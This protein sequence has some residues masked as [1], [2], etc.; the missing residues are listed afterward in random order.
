MHAYLSDFAVLAIVVLALL[1][2]AREGFTPLR[3]GRWLWIAMAA[4]LI[5]VVV[6]VGLG[7]V[8]SAAYPWRTH[9]V[10]AA[11]W[12]EYALLAPAVPLLVRRRSDLV[13]MLWSLALWSAAATCAGL[14]EFA[15]AHIFYF[16]RV[17]GRQGSFLSESD[18]AALSGAVLLVGLIAL[19]V[20]RAELGR[21]LGA[22]ATA[23]G[24][25][26]VALAGAVASVFG[27]ATGGA[28]VAARLLR[29]GALSRTRVL[30]AGGIAVLAAAGVV[31]LRGGDIAS[32][33]HFVG[34]SGG[35]QKT[36]Q[37]YAQHTLL[38]WIGIQI[39]KDRPVLGAGWEASEDPAT[40][41]PYLAAAHRR[42]PSEPPLAF[43]SRAHT[44]NVQ[45]AW[46]EALSDLG[47]VG[48]VLF[49][50][51][52]ATAGWYAWRAGSLIALGWI[53][54]VAWLWAA[55]SFV[56]GI[57]LDAVTWLGFGLAATPAAWRST[58]G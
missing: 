24:A 16:G 13:P 41:E 20:P 48:L 15:G 5:W 10:T 40:F 53:G 27:L 17:G 51:M 18:F 36:V 19:L 46:V 33:G 56:A 11:K 7:R 3:S 55:Q 30:I 49:A 58:R 31:A 26:G 57:P 35:R 47:L 25:I 21:R 2:G 42:F 32:F 43:P 23:A 29:S 6:E 22:S 39:W 9:A 8:H 14:A 34:A 28:L 44:Y 12:I 1:T 54:L 50:A 37:T 4:F 52:F 38:A 45:N